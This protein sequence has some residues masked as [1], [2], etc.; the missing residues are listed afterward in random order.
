MDL[1]TDG[2]SPTKTKMAESSLLDKPWRKF[3]EFNE[4]VQYS[5]QIMTLLQIGNNW[6]NL[7]L[8][9]MCL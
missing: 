5:N 7:V 3:P 8:C 4:E 9:S 6:Q 1:F 2:P